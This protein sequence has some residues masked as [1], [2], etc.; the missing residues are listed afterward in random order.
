MNRNKEEIKKSFATANIPAA[1]TDIMEV[2]RV[3]IP[4]AT[5]IP[6]T[7]MTMKFAAIEIADNLLK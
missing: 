3:V 2:N 6:I 7:G 5:I 4:I 1:H